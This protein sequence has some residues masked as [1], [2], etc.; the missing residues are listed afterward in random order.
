MPVEASS[1]SGSRLSGPPAAQPLVS[2]VIPTYNRAH[3]LPRALNACLGQTYRNIEVI[4]VN[5][6]SKDGTPDLLREY[7]QRD[8]RVRAINKANEG[9]PDTVNRGFEAARGQYVTWTSDDNYYYP[10]AIEA[11]V[12]FLEAHRDVAMVYTD[13]RFVDGEGRDLGVVEA[14]EPES[15]EYHCAPAG[16]L[17]FRRQVFDKVEMFRRRWVRCHDFDF[18]HRVYKRFKVA[19]LPKV[20]YVYQA[21]DA[22]M[23]GDHVAHVVEEAELLAHHARHP[24]E[25]P[26]IWARAYAH[27]GQWAAN[28]GRWWTSCRYFAR[29]ARYDSRHWRPAVRS[30]LVAIYGL[31]P[32][33]A[34]RCWRALKRR[35]STA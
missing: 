21:H 6:G 16:C 4:V 12:A 15:L 22:S 3:L 9:I 26:K 28:R 34:K 10:E 29:A 20:L 13:S 24:A 2:I 14:L 17:L 5:D 32:G 1:E 11:M 30:F 31:V 8:H 27:L 7:A 19:R 25:R 33:F 18:Y 23:S 35:P